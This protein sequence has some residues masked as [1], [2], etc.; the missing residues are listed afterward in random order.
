[1]VSNPPPSCTRKLTGLVDYQILGWFVESMN[2]RFLVP[3]TILNLAS[4]VIILVAMFNAKAGGYKFDHFDPN[5]LLSA[6]YE[7]GDGQPMEWE[8]Q[9]KYC[10]DV[11]DSHI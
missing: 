9:V 11:R 8:D 2:V 7:V 4:L 3:M 1:M 6:S 5:E 10:P